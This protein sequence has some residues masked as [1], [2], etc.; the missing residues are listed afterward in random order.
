MDKRNYLNY[1][2][3]AMIRSEETE[4]GKVEG[5]QENRHPNLCIYFNLAFLRGNAKVAYYLSVAFSAAVHN[6]GGFSRGGRVEG[7]SLCVLEKKLSSPSHAFTGYTYLS[8]FVRTLH[9]SVPCIAAQR[10]DTVDL[11]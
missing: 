11:D 10:K 6:D 1:L 4:S 8:S 7:I 2:A 3:V 9:L 5:T